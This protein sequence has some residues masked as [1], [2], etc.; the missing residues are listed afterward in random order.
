M[1]LYRHAPNK[2]ALLNG[3]AEMVL[4]QLTVNTTD[5]DW[6]ASCVPS[7]AVT[8]LSPS[9]IHMWYRCSSRG[10]WPHRWRC[11]PSH[12]PP[13]RKRPRAADPGRFTG[14]D[15]LHIYRALFGFLHGHVLD[16]LQE[17][18]DNPDETD[19]VLR[20]GCTGCRSAS[21][22]S[23]AVSP[24]C[25]RAMRARGART[26]SR[27]PAHGAYRRRYPAA[28]VRRT[29]GRHAHGGSD[30]KPKMPQTENAANRGPSIV[31]WARSLRPRDRRSRRTGR[32][33]SYLVISA[34]R[35]PG[36][37]RRRTGCPPAAG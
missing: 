33:G 37:R 24:P 36:S 12:T 31:C 13:A 23:C 26:R 7:P 11:A 22:P 21:F 1:I 10:R 18:V 14:P 4:A 5:P 6:Q 35:R 15:A 8:A 20:W 19:D 2:A 27:H 28:Q 29:L 9:P 25:W 30:R 32:Y 3:V 17:V 34:A 16:E